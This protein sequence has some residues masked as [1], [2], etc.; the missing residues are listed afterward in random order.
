M[1]RD[2]HR[3]FAPI[4][5]LAC[6]ACSGTGQPD[7][8]YAAFAAPAT[9]GTVSADHG[10]S[11]TLDQ[12]TVA[13]GPVYFCASESGSATLCQTAIGELL[14]TTAFDALDPAPRAL[15]T[16]HGF[17][18]KIQ[19]ASYDYGIHWFLTD[20]APTPGPAAPG[21]HSAHF[22]GTATKPGKTVHFRAEVDVV[23]QFQGQRAA[24]SQVATATITGEGEKLDIHFAVG[25]WF[26]HVD[27][28]EAPAGADPYVI[29]AGSRNHGAIVIGMT[30]ESPP[31]FVWSA[32]P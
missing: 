12:A 19:S 24:P 16:A 26:E 31:T 11:V 13:F 9:P 2:L 3:S 21:G 29:S 25:Q 10:W 8:D 23:P 17:I 27:F 20:D 28:D 30:A 5:L 22:S 18:G 15:G 4:A 7:V 32:A 14:T 1:L 6:A